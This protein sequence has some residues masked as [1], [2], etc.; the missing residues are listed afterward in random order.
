MS[1][2]LSRCSP[3]CRRMRQYASM[4]SPAPCGG[5]PLATNGAAMPWMY[6]LASS[7]CRSFISGIMAIFIISA[8][9]P[10]R[11]EVLRCLTLSHLKRIASYA[12]TGRTAAS[13]VG[14]R[15]ICL[16]RLTALALTVIP[17]VHAPA[18]TMAA[19][20]CAFTGTAAAPARPMILPIRWKEVD[21]MIHVD[22]FPLGCL[23]VC[24]GFYD[25]DIGCC[26]CPPLEMDYAC[27]LSD[28]E[29]LNACLGEGGG[30]DA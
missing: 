13:A 8:S 29:E 15:R 22:D 11:K 1:L 16:I 18:M 30:A 6:P 17:A 2:T 24:C 9:P 12:T 28:V 5:L 21:L 10:A 14:C 25:R 20:P 4:A 19:A 27:P 7:A 26:L 3:S 23:R